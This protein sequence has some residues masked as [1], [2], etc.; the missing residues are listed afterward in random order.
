MASLGIDDW[1]GSDTKTLILIQ[2]RYASLERLMEDAAI[3]IAADITDLAICKSVIVG[4]WLRRMIS[5]NR[6]FKSQIWK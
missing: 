2:F 3:G 6:H 1:A 4:I 5:Q